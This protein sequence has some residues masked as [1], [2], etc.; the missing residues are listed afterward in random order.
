MVSPEKEELACDKPR[1]KSGI[2]ERRPAEI[3]RDPANLEALKERLLFFFSDQNA[4]RCHSFRIKFLLKDDGR[5]PLTKLLQY[6]SIRKYTMSL[7]T[8]SY[9]VQT[10]CQDVLTVTDDGRGIRRIKP[11][12]SDLLRD[13][14]DQSLYLEGIPFDTKSLKYTV[15]A[16]DIEALFQKEISLVKLRYR[17]PRLEGEYGRKFR[18]I[19]VGTAQV[20]FRHMD[21][22][23]QAASEY[24]TYR[25]GQVHSPAKILQLQNNILSVALFREYV[26]YR[27][28]EKRKRTAFERAELEKERKA[29]ESKKQDCPKCL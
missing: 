21:D 27:K 2:D 25:D 4:R 20:E 15:T 19:P 17:P 22:F 6:P 9:V 7:D 11:I 16:E 13:K 10:M 3:H 1:T 26:D 28:E 5:V 18:R 23:Q 29:A 14:V 24:L 12:T 8:I